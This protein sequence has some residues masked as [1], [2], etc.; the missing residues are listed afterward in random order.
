MRCVIQSRGQRLDD[1]QPF[2]FAEKLLSKAVS[3]KLNVVTPTSRTVQLA[4]QRPKKDAK[5]MEPDLNYILLLVINWIFYPYKII[6][7]NQS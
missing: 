6:H 7:I 5:A 4:P 1:L 3:V 2:Q